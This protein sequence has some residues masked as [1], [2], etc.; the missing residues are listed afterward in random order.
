MT[1]LPN[2]KI[3]GL[4]GMSGAGKSTVCE[5]FLECGFSVID[6]DD[7]AHAVTSA[8]MP[9]VA[10]LAK[11]LSPEIVNAD[12]SLNR[13]AT[14]RMIFADPHKREVFNSVVYPYIRYMIISLIKQYAKKGA[15]VLLD[16]P[17][18]FEARLECICTEIVSVCADNELCAKRI[19]ERDRISHEDALN[20][21]KSQH[22]I[23]FF[24]RNSDIVIEN[25]GTRE[26]LFEAAHAAAEQLKGDK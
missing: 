5:F 23:E 2:I 25:N 13:R 22:D 20:R 18:L 16:A 10:E 3:I 9:C 12:G 8:G 6:C 11:R 14:G 21:L 1:Q 19:M 17:T 15:D 7:C 24:R 4:T 26:Q